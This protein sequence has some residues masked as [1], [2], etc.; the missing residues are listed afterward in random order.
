MMRDRWRKA[1]L[2]IMLCNAGYSWTGELSPIFLPMLEGEWKIDS[3]SSIYGPTTLNRCFT[4][5]QLMSLY[6]H[7]PLIDQMNNNAD[8]CK[9]TSELKRNSEFYS[10]VCN[11]SNVITTQTYHLVKESYDR[12]VLEKS[13]SIEPFTP[14]ID[15]LETII[16]TRIGRCQ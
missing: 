2:V 3:D 1:L 14:A 12:Y 15:S 11:E 5:E 8:D 16:F 13:V 7:Q 10:L 4:G 6:S 9:I